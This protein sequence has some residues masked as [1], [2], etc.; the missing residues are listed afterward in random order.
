MI[1]V[2]EPQKVTWDLR[3]GFQIVWRSTTDARQ[4]GLLHLPIGEIPAGRYKLEATTTASSY[5]TDL[6][7]QA[8][9]DARASEQIISYNANLAPSLR[10][11][12]IGHQWLLRG[13]IGQAKQSLRA[14]L[15]AGATQAAEIELARVDALSGNLDDGRDLV[16]NV[17]R[18]Q[19][20]NFEALA[21]LAY[22]EA[23][24]QD[25]RVAADLYRQALAVQDSVAVREALAQLPQR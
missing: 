19:P 18:R 17:L 24:F 6:T 21:V 14:S 1:P 13:N 7:L 2:S 11:A 5:A 23:K 9:D 12:A 8:S 22:I 16:R 20:K 10:Y 25:Y 15:D 3:K 4:L